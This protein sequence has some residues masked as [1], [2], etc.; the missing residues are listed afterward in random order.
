MEKK[1]N[2]SKIFLK[3]KYFLLKMEPTYELVER[4]IILMERL[5]DAVDSR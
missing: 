1:L 2:K 3:I 5:L 4:F